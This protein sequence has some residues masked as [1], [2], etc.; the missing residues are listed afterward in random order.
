MATRA[1]TF[2]N[3]SKEVMTTNALLLVVVNRLGHVKKL[4]KRGK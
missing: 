4:M 3:V 2:S 1:T